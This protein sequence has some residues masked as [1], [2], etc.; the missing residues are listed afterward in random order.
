MRAYFEHNLSR[1]EF[2]QRSL[3]AGG[4]LFT[5]FDRL[6]LPAIAAAPAD[7]PFRGGRMLGLA[8]F[9]GEAPVPMGAAFGKE[10]DGRLYTDLSQLTP[11][12]R[13]TPAEKFYIRTRASELLPNAQSWMVRLGGL[14]ARPGEIPA[15]ELRREARPMGLRL[16][17]CA[18][19]VHAVH[20]GLMSA[21]KWA[22]VPVA[23][24]LARARAKPQATRVLVSGFDRYATPSVSSVPGASWVFTLNELES[25]G[26]FLATE[27]DGAPLARDHGAP[28]RLVAPGWYGCAC[29][30]WV[31]E[32]TLVDDSRGATSQMRE[33]ASRTMQDGVPQMAK[34][35]K[36]AV[37]DQAAMPIRVEKWL[38]SGK[39]KYRVVGILWGGNR[40]VK[41][42]EIRFNP[43][44][45]YVPVDWFH[46]PAND[47]WSLWAH[48]WTPRQPGEYLIRLRVAEPRVVARRL[49]AGFY[50]RAVEIGEV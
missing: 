6:P 38:V 17:E 30:K 13:V 7:D 46:Q 15:A 19:N 2:L 31:N 40:P 39:I 36:P 22:G 4:V 50:V 3:I 32:I 27:L 48:P 24:I 8:A 47:P 45:D 21:G 42:L 18:G 25:A 26:A 10:L 28:L 12:S 35:Y 44:E 1:R 43:E 16:M 34:D 41:K 9:T 37:V 20:F 23:E 29:I 11:E 14:V 49:D 33:Y 5:G